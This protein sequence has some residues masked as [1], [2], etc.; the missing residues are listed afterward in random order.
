[1]HKIFKSLPERYYDFWIKF[2][3]FKEKTKI[4]HVDFKERWT[5]IIFSQKKY[6]FFILA[7]SFIVNIFQTLLPR[8]LGYIVENRNHAHYLM[9]IGAWGVSVIIEFIILY[10]AAILEVQCVS[11]IQYNAFRFF[12]TVDP[13]YHSK[14]ES[15]KVFAKIER[16]ARA[17]EDL[18]DITL[19]D[20]FSMLISII[21][22][23]GSFFY[24]SF[25][26]GIMSFIL[27]SLVALI[28]ISLILFY[29]R[30]FEKNLIKADDS[31][32]VLSVESLTQVQLIR[33]Y[34]ASTYIAKKIKKFCHGLMYKIASS[35]LSI[36]SIVMVTRVVYLFSIAIIGLQILNNIESNIISATV[37][38]TLIVTYLRSTSEIIRLGRRIGKLAKLITRIKDLFSFINDFGKQT[39]PVLP[40]DI[41]NTE[42]LNNLDTK[43]AELKLLSGNIKLEARDLYFDYDPKAVIFE[44]HNL[45]LEIGKNQKNKLYGVIGPS[46][47]GKTTLISILGGQLRPTSGS[48]C[49]NNISIY[50]IDDEER[51]KLIAIQAQVSSNL[52]G[53]IKKNLLLGL[54]NGIYSDEE[55]ISVLKEVG[56]WSIILEKD[57]L[58]THVGEGGLNLSVG[59]RQRLNFAS[60]YLRAQ[61]YKPLLILIDEPTSSLDEVSELAITN[62]INKIAQDSLTLVIAHRLRTLKDAVAILDFSLIQAK[63]I[64]FY[65]ESEL[66]AI[67]P[68]FK[69]LIVGHVDIE[70]IN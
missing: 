35:W 54:P 53:T 52:S 65:K 25:K 64:K 44:H 48:V 50:D 4:L 56:I 60:M 28:N 17:Y 33:S 37:G 27:L 36:S 69:K 8:I 32:K 55:I 59:Q 30:A 6:L 2:T 7:L 26:L 16:A 61:Y 15:G 42:I 31:L 63:D 70:N 22:V 13:I 19:F 38:L 9:F 49:L 10:C 40:L 3:N 68:Y 47:M 5:N 39:F 18:L 41:K 24:I 29:T 1:M 21:T 67:S 12:L 58:N 51:R 66:R 11:S 23:V 62:M 45:Y 20:L 34:F 43:I 46:G 57:G 14:R